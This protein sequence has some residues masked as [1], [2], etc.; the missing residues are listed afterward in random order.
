MQKEHAGVC[1]NPE[2][3]PPLRCQVPTSSQE[4]LAILEECCQLD[5]TA[6]FNESTLMERGLGQSRYMRRK[7]AANYHYHVERWRGLTKPTDEHMPLLS[8]TGLDG[9]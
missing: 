6:H 5:S 2:F 8:R 1:D 4:R 3:L 9:F 7:Y